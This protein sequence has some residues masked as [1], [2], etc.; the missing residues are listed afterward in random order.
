ME[1]LL[2]TSPTNL[3]RTPASTAASPGWTAAGGVALNEWGGVG[4]PPPA[5]TRAAS[6]RPSRWRHSRA[7][8]CVRSTPHPRALAPRSSG[9]LPRQRRGSC[10]RSPRSPW[11]GS[12]PAQLAELVASAPAERHT[13]GSRSRLREDATCS[14]TSHAD[15]ALTSAR[16]RSLRGSASPRY[17]V[18]RV[19]PVASSHRPSMSS[20][21]DRSK[22]TAFLV[23]GVLLFEDSWPSSTGS[24]CA[25]HGSS[26]PRE[27]PGTRSPPPSSSRV[28]EDG[29]GRATALSQAAGPP[30]VPGGRRGVR[31]EPLRVRREP[32][33]TGPSPEGRRRAPG[34]LLGHGPRR[35][36]GPGERRSPRGRERASPPRP[37]LPGPLPPFP[38][39]LLARLFLG[40]RRRGLSKIEARFVMVDTENDLVLAKVPGHPVSVFLAFAGILGFVATF[41]LVLGVGF[42]VRGRAR[43]AR[44]E[45]H[46][47]RRVARDGH[48]VARRARRPARFLHVD[49]DRW[50]FAYPADGEST[51]LPKSPSS[52]SPP[53]R[54]TRRS[55]TSGSTNTSSCSR[56][57]R[58]RGHDVPLPGPGVRRP[59]SS[60][61]SFGIASPRR[62]LRAAGQPFPRGRSRPALPWPMSTRAVRRP[63]GGAAGP[64]SG[65]VPSIH[66][67]EGDAS[68]TASKPAGSRRR[69]PR[70]RARHLAA[71]PRDEVRVLQPSRILEREDQVAADPSRGDRG[72]RIRGAC[73]CVCVCVCVCA[74]PSAVARRLR[75]SGASKR[76]RVTPRAAPHRLHPQREGGSAAP[77]Q[78]ES[79]KSGSGPRLKGC[80]PR[81]AGAR[82]APLALEV[83]GVR[84]AVQLEGAGARR[85][86]RAQRPAGRGLRTT[87]S[88]Q[89]PAPREPLTASPRL[90]GLGLDVEVRCFDRV[91]HGRVGHEARQ[92][93]RHQRPVGLVGV[94]AEEGPPREGEELLRIVDAPRP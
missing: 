18:A 86:T 46:R 14:S 3:W 15:R 39:W 9:H 38:L 16:G 35:P 88:V 31:V 6:C 81:C 58:G 23:L 59:A 30:R 91:R 7:T 64:A 34:G 8:G 55:T 52:E 49:L 94:D 83:E 67:G 10:S 21:P 42:P 78:E 63:S 19:A 53:P 40:C 82:A 51:P 43:D 13:S 85:S 22:G 20:S 66:A 2:S 71:Q 12:A 77:G 62:R 69:M 36:R 41:V 73:V 32:A 89:I 4:C 48:R 92:R 24:S 87:T 84:H 80:L 57:P 45:H 26:R 60:W 28:L 25:S 11:L 72:R 27:T 47:D 33:R 65:P 74:R 5:S 17:L 79:T 68:L 50:S 70:P 54:P 90:E 93:A 44:P 1:E 29:V 75:L 76:S 61:R 56:T 37:G